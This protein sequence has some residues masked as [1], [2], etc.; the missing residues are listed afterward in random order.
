M[1]KERIKRGTKLSCFPRKGLTTVIRYP[2]AVPLVPSLEALQDLTILFVCIFHGAWPR[3]SQGRRRTHGSILEKPGSAFNYAGD[4]AGAGGDGRGRD[5]RDQ[6]TKA[7]SLANAVDIT[8]NPRWIATKT[9]CSATGIW[10]FR[11]NM[12][13]LV[14][15][16]DWGGECDRVSAATDPFREASFFGSKSLVQ[17]FFH[18]NLAART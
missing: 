8:L 6:M 7:F 5:E 18:T 11:W 17:Q 15:L 13:S 4:T 1:E 16:N 9:V 14:T 12:D 3:S 10:E 2:L